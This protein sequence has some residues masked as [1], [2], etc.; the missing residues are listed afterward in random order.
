[1]LGSLIAVPIMVMVL[2]LMVRALAFEF[3]HHS[4][5]KPL[6]SKAFSAGSAL[7]VLG[8]AF[9][10][11]GLLS[12][13]V[14]DGRWTTLFSPFSIMLAL[15]VATGYVMLGYAYLVRHTESSVRRASFRGLRNSAIASFVFAIFIFTLLPPVFSDAA[16]VWTGPLRFVFLSLLAVLALSYSMTVTASRRPTHSRSPY[17]WAVASVVCVS[18]F[19]TLTIYPTIIP[20]EL[21]VQT[22]AATTKTLTFMLYGL[23]P[24]IPI[25]LFYN[26]Y[27]HRLFGGTMEPEEIYEEE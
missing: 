17:W 13:V 8:Q 1:M 21:T 10:V 26:I 3:H 23:L 20:G 5:H 11:G 24:I 7:A 2:G 16:S 19:A 15:A 6:W 14:T 22:A 27:V 25:V 9:T 12:G 4:E 18:G